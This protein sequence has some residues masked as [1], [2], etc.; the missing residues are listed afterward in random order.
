MLFHVFPFSYVGGQKQ[1]RQDPWFFRE[2]TLERVD[3]APLRGLSIAGVWRVRCLCHMHTESCAR[4]RGVM[5]MA[6]TSRKI[7]ENMVKVIIVKGFCKVPREWS[8]FSMFSVFLIM[9]IR[10]VVAAE[11]IPGELC[12]VRVV[13]RKSYVQESL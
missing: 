7:T 12:K 4:C 10:K 5:L 8:C 1:R 6:R 13:Q 9:N 2:L 11:T 3:G